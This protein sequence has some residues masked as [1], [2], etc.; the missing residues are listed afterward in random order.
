MDDGLINPGKLLSDRPAQGGA[1]S[2]TPARKNRTDFTSSR[3]C[4]RT[5]KTCGPP[6]S[7]VWVANIS[8][9]SLRYSAV[10]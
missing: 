6:S 10:R 4:S 5:R 9:P 8:C 7:T 1:S 3:W 2:P